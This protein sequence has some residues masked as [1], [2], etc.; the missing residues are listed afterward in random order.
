MGSAGLLSHLER[1]FPRSGSSQYIN[2]G[3]WA[4]LI[5]I[6]NDDLGVRGGREVGAGN[7]RGVRRMAGV[8]DDGEA[9]T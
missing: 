8:Y 5:E 1:C 4:R 7:C 9:R 2:T 6:S 3:T